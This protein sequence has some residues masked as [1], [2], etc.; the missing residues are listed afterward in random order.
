MEYDNIPFKNKKYQY[1][2]SVKGEWG[3]NY[4]DIVTLV[5]KKVANFYK[6][7]RFGMKIKK[8]MFQEIL[9]LI[10]SIII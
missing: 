7:I 3:C 2:G 5:Q 9:F 1:R 10:L 8:N 6:E 4:K